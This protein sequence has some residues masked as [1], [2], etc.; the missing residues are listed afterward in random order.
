[1]LVLQKVSLAIFHYLR[2]EVFRYCHPSCTVFVGWFVCSLTSGHW[3]RAQATAG[4]PGQSRS[5]RIV[6]CNDW[7]LAEVAVYDCFV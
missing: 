6:G 7:L 5:Q 4:E 2:Q 3:C 1:M